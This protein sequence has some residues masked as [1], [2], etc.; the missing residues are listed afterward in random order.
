MIAPLVSLRGRDFIDVAD[1]APSDLRRVLDLASEIKAGRWKDRPL[2]GRHM[3]MLFQRPSHRTRVSF[4]VGIARLGGTTTTLTSQDVQLGYRESIADAA[5]VLD[6]YVDGI[7]ARLRSHGDLLQLALFS[8]KPV[9]NALTDRSHPCQALADLLTLE[10]VRG[11]LARQRVVYIGDGNNMANSL[12]EASS[13]GGF[14]L[15]IVTPPG[16]DPDPAIV[17]RARGVNSGKNHVTLT[18]QIDVR[19][20][21]AIYTDVWASMGQ[22]DERA[23]RQNVFGPYQVNARVMD[24]APEAVFMHCLPAHRGEEVTDEVIDGPRSVVFQQAEN[25]LYAQM[26]LLAELF[27]E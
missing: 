5:R 13:V 20:A 16:Y 9:I 3:A 2:E 1:L 27:G 8:E 21:T 15:T 6:R 4:E 12:I 23:T 26:A 17:Q 18:N 19:G 10:E 25:R 11:E 22:E 14:A 7:I 24:Q